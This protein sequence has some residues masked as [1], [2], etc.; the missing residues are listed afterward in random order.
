MHGARRTPE[1]KV[2]NRY[3]NIAIEEHG[4]SAA[5]IF[6]Q[7]RLSIR[8]VSYR[9]GFPNYGTWRGRAPSGWP[10]PAKFVVR[11]LALRPVSE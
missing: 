9:S 7:G 4:I 6:G 11:A 3:S 8:A 1:T 2:S 10:T 5:A